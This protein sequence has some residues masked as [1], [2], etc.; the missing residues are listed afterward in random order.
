MLTSTSPLL[1]FR[2]MVM[3][4]WRTMYSNSLPSSL[5][6]GAPLAS[7]FHC[8]LEGLAGADLRASSAQASLSCVLVYVDISASARVLL[9]S[10]SLY[11]CLSLSLKRGES[12]C[13]CVYHPRRSR[14]HTNTTQHLESQPQQQQQQH[15]QRTLDVYIRARVYLSM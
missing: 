11:N 2:P 10:S 5:A 13:A 14:T 1:L 4:L 6:M 3:R 9:L 15:M 7:R 12:E 8:I